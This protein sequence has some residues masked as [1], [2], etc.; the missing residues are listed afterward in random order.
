MSRKPLLPS[1]SERELIAASKTHTLE[2]LAEQFQTSPGSVLRKA[3][4]LGLSIKRTA[5]AKWSQARTQ[6]A[7]HGRQRR[8]RNFW[9]C[10][11][12]K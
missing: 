3:A 7:D 6:K 1:M 4:K 8:T 2:A 10:S 9:R 12:L 5:N 11:T